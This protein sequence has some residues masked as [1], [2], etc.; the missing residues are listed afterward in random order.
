MSEIK[1]AGSIK[2]F[3]QPFVTT[4]KSKYSYVKSTDP[5]GIYEELLSLE[6]TLDAQALPGD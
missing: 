5:L 2:D 4:F 3:L 1:E 6:G